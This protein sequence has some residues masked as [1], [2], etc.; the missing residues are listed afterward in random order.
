MIRQ[1]D[2]SLN[3][4]QG[5]GKIFDESPA[6]CARAPGRVNIIGEHT[7][8]ND[9]FVLPMAIDRSV[10]VACGPGTGESIR[11]HSNLYGF[12]EINLTDID[13]HTGDGWTV[14]IA[15]VIAGIRNHGITVPS[16]NLYIDST[17]PVGKGLSS[18]AA[19]EVA[20]ALAI[21]EILQIRMDYRMVADLCREAEHRYAGMP[22]GIMD[23]YAS[24]F[25]TPGHALLIDCRTGV[26]QPIALDAGYTFM[27]FDSG[28]DRAL[29]ST[30]YG[31]RRRECEEALRWLGKYIPD[32]R[33]FRDIDKESFLAY[34]GRMPRILFKRAFH[35]L[36][37]NNRVI[38][39]VDAVRAGDVKLLGRLMFKS[40]GSLSRNFDASTPALDNLVHMAKASCYIAGA[41]L[42]GGGFGGYTINLV[43]AGDFIRARDDIGQEGIPVKT[44]RGA[45]SWTI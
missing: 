35:V 8:Y 12:A 37:E 2:S 29:V 42:H 15:G 41:R 17:I 38:K 31:E 25:G 26:F 32:T 3:L 28:E 39:A 43:I 16:L 20:T 4:I 5:Y 18:S 44:D 22:C 34:K 19:L 36:S 13:K 14:Y 23:H 40:H 27:L 10:W 7:D 30:G 1:P 24:L 9:G 33:S 11:C 45:E 6:V 21:L